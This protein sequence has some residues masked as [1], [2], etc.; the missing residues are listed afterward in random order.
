MERHAGFEELLPAELAREGAGRRHLR[1]LKSSVLQTK[2]VA[3]SDFW[4][5][6]ARLL[7]QGAVAD[8][9]TGSGLWRG[10]FQKNLGNR[11]GF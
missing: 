8:L 2:K 4:Y 1:F 10:S 9:R 6:H 7:D 3:E 11:L 5:L